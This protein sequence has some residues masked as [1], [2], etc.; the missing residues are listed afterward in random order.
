M[1]L[2][3][4]VATVVGVAGMGTIPTRALWMAVPVSILAAF[5]G[6][7][8]VKRMQHERLKYKECE[9]VQE[10]RFILDS[11]TALMNDFVGMPTYALHMSAPVSDK[12]RAWVESAAREIESKYGKTERAFFLDTSSTPSKWS[13]QDV[14]AEVWIDKKNQLNGNLA[15]LR[16][17]IEKRL[18]LCN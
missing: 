3:I 5:F 17:L 4:D 14:N 9:S 6:A 8:H 1:I 11:G 7:F 10:L 16:H 18:L 15:N 13:T 12:Y 2:L